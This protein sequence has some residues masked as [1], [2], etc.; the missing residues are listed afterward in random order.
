[1]SRKSDAVSTTLDSAEDAEET[2]QSKAKSLTQVNNVALQ[3]LQMLRASSENIAVDDEADKK[4]RFG[5]C[6]FCC[7]VARGFI[8]LFAVGLR[9]QQMRRVGFTSKKHSRA[10]RLPTID[11]VRACAR[12]PQRRSFVKPASVVFYICMYYF[13]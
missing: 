10:E 6:A 9:Q 11:E 4:Q 5:I 13:C 7:S 12:S 2:E 1:M 3:R 8:V